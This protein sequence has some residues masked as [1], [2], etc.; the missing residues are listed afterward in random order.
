[1]LSDNPGWIATFLILQV[2]IDE[3][4]LDEDLKTK[5][6]QKRHK[7]IPWSLMEDY[8]RIICDDK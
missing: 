5:C 3:D 7:Q 6:W 2:A 8:P 1:M 4:A